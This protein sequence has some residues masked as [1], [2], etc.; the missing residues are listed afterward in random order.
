MKK[1][2]SYLLLIVS[3]CVTNSYAQKTAT[4]DDYYKGKIR[5]K[6]KE[7]FFS[8]IANSRVAVGNTSEETDVLG[9][10]SID[11]LSENN[12][13]WRI[14]RVFPYSPKHEAKHRK[15]GLHLWYELDFEGDMNPALL[16][17]QYAILNEVAIAK[18]LFKKVSLAAGA[19]PVYWSK[20]VESDSI[21]AG[22]LKVSQK[23]TA[24]TGIN[25]FS[26]ARV[27]GVQN[28]ND[29]FLNLQWHYQNDGSITG[30]KGADIDL[31]AAWSI[32][33]NDT[34]ELK[35]VVV[36]V[37]DGGIDI[38][39]EDLV[40]NLWINEAE[41]YGTE[42]VDDDG[43]GYID[44]IH[45]YNFV[46]GSSNIS[47]HA[48]GTHVAGTVGAVSNNG[49][50]VA[51]VAGGDGNGNGVKLISCQV[52]DNQVRGTGVDDF[53]NAIIY[54]A[55]NGAVISQN[56]WGYTVPGKQEEEV[57]DA[58]QYFI[59][60]AGRYEGSPMQGGILIFAAGNTGYNDEHY[61]AAYDEVV[62]VAALGP[63]DSIAT[64]STHGTW[65]DISAP[66]GDLLAFGEEGQIYSTLP[67]NNYG[68]MEGT[69][70]ATPHVSGVAALA[71]A[72]FGGENFRPEDLRSMLLG[73][74]DPLAWNE[75]GYFGVGALNARNV[76]SEDARIAPEAITDLSAAETYHDAIE[77]SWTVPVDED[78]FQPELFYLSLDREEIT[79][80]N[81]GEQ[82]YNF[83]Y[84]NNYEAGD[85]ITLT[86]NGLLKQTDYWFAIKSADR[87]GN[88]SNLSNILKV[89]TTDVPKFAESTRSI[90]LNINVED[91]P[92]QVVPVTFANDGDGVISWSAFS[93]NE[94][95]A[96]IPLED[97]SFAQQEAQQ[98]VLAAPHRYLPTEPQLMQASVSS[99][100]D[101]PNYI[102]YDNT[103]VRAGFRYYNDQGHGVTLAGSGSK[104]SGLV[105]STRFRVPR[106]ADFNWTHVR[107]V[108]YLTQKEKPVIVELKKGAENVQDAETFYVQEY[109]ADTTDIVSYHNI[110]IYRP[111][112]LEG[113]EYFF[114]VLHFPKEEAFPLLLQENNYSGD[115]T[116]YFMMSMDKGVSF[117]DAYSIYNR[118]FPYVDALSSGEDG[119]YVFINPLEGKI[120]AGESM[121]VDVTVDGTNLT[122]GY[123][124]NTIGITT[125]D[126][127]KPGISIEVKTAVT[128]QKPAVEFTEKQYKYEVYQGVE[129]DLAVSIRNTGLDTLTVTGLE[130]NG[131]TILLDSEVKI[132]AQTNGLVVFD[133]VAS[134]LGLYAGNASLLTDTENGAERFNVVITTIEQ[135]EIEA[136]LISP[137]DLMFNYD[138]TATVEL[139]VTN[140][141]SSIVSYDL[142]HYHIG[143]A[144][145]GL[146][147]EKLAYKVTS[148]DEDGGPVEGTW[149]DITEVGEF[150]GT[151]LQML[152]SQYDL[153]TAFPYYN[154]MLQTLRIAPSYGVLYVNELRGLADA[155]NAI[156][157]LTSQQIEIIEMYQYAFGDREVFTFKNTFN[158]GLRKTDGEIDFYVQV[159]FFRDGA[160]EFRYKGVDEAWAEKEHDYMI[161]IQGV[162]EDDKLLYKEEKGITPKIHDGLVIRFEPKEGS[163]VSMV[164]DASSYK[165]E[166]L[167]SE[168]KSI[169][170]TLNPSYYNLFEGAY[171]NSVILKSNSTTPELEF[172][173]DITLL[174]DSE[175]SILE[176]ENTEILFDTVRIGLSQEKYFLVRNTGRKPVVLNSL[177]FG[178]NLD[179]TS[180]VSLP[181]TINPLSHTFIPIIFEPKSN[182]ETSVAVAYNFD[183]GQTGFVDL[184]GVGESDVA[185]T[186]TGLPEHLEVNL[187]T[188][189]EK[190]FTF[191]LANAAEDTH[192]QY[193][194]ENGTHVRLASASGTL[195]ENSERFMVADYGYRWHFSDETKSTYKWKDIEGEGE[196]IEAGNY[197]QKA[198]ALP[199]A[200][201][202][203]GKMYD[204]LWV[205]DNGYVAVN[206]LEE[207]EYNTA[208]EEG[209]GM[210]GL[211]APF[212]STLKIIDDA[213]G[214]HYLA[215]ED[216]VYFQWSA[217]GEDV[218]NSPGHVVFQVEILKDGRIFFH[219]NKL[220]G[221]QGILQYGLESPDEKYDLNKLTTW[222]LRWSGLTDSTTVSIATPVMGKT[223]VG[224]T[225]DFEFKVASDR[226]FKAGTYQDT[227]RI[228]TNSIAQPMFE[229]PVTLNV[230]G[231]PVLTVTDSLVWE[232]KTVLTSGLTLEKKFT[233][234]N[235][236]T[237]NLNISKITYEGLDN[238]TLYDGEGEEV[239]LSFSGTLISPIGVEPWETTTL[240]VA[241]PVEQVGDIEGKINI[242]TNAD[243][244]ESVAVKASI[245]ESPVFDWDATN[246][247]YS[248]NATDTLEYTFQ[249]ETKGISEADLDIL[250]LP[251]VIPTVNE[252]ENQGPVYDEI[253]DLILDDVL[254]MDS[255]TWEKKEE[256]DGVFN[257]IL[258]GSR[259]Y[260]NSFIAPERGF[261]MTHVK[262]FTNINAVQE[263]VKISIYVGGGI[264]AGR[265]EGPNTTG[266][267]AYQQ[268]YIVHQEI[269]D[270][271]VTYAFKKPI[272]IPGGERFWVVIDQPATFGSNYYHGFESTLDVDVQQT[273]WM[274]NKRGE[275]NFFWMDFG[276]SEKVVWKMRPL[277][278]AGE[279]SWLTLTPSGVTLEQGAEAVTVTAK[280]LPEFAEIGFNRAKIVAQTNDVNN[281]KLD[282]D[283][284][285]TINGAPQFE[286]S[287][288]QYVDTL[289]ITETE[290]YVG[291]YYYT[292]PEGEELSISFGDNYDQL[293]ARF[294]ET[295]SHTA[296]LKI[297]TDYE[298][299]GVYDYPVQLSDASG[300]TIYDTL[301]VEV[302]D[303]NRPPY[304]KEEYRQLFLNLADSV[305]GVTLAASD[306]F[307]DPDGDFVAIGLSGYTGNMFDL[308]IG[309]SYLD[310]H[311]RMAGHGLIG[312]IAS[313][314]REDGFVSYIIDVYISEESEEDAQ[315]SA[316]SVEKEVKEQMKEFGVSTMVYPNPMKSSDFVN[317]AFKLEEQA[318]VSV[319]I[320]DM[321]G[322]IVASVSEVDFKK[323][324]YKLP[325]NMSLASE[326]MYISRLIVNG[327]VVETEKILKSL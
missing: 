54:G 94:H 3:L 314:F 58:I 218:N 161:G 174:D 236:G 19:K 59:E 14:K 69:S 38:V 170:I 285:V 55:D 83:Q 205:S 268:R 280:V 227:L 260:A 79:E 172:P 6:L 221:W 213:K 258:G 24:N 308:A 17:E 278:A 111:Q 310:I 225:T 313:D 48:H 316:Y 165:G 18:P 88:V 146:M 203:Y 286:Y 271:W 95:P 305:E 127:Y 118:I 128:G 224:Q 85:T 74:T 245:V 64:Y 261:T 106:E 292:D 202:F 321:Y 75:E 180:R 270:Q 304:L 289:R 144:M 155:R 249:V 220:E 16:A 131:E 22:K 233:V 248:I 49:I 287:P 255:V 66:G 237:S 53:A 188:G 101:V 70:M 142:S 44:D 275:D 77:L 162:D 10:S 164:A 108:M 284:E 159:A 52:F 151:Q 41:M 147:S 217:L 99:L 137:S 267:L 229:V 11:N 140:T 197:R 263:Y 114:V 43:N 214:V 78:N 216:R 173:L 299:A 246:Q 168:S 298:S 31:F 196:I 103:Q 327:K 232:D 65:V 72:Y 323:G 253:G 158:T 39:H 123:H 302:V 42:G 102:K 125:N 190:T 23:A 36:A 163:Y 184:E 26:N 90:E 96:Y 243:N 206:P 32:V 192:V 208:F 315:A 87:F 68:Y 1:V 201:P 61:P 204:T 264:P 303:K 191:S 178:D 71:V 244:D 141:S 324:T 195:G 51:G 76:L 291:N 181:L 13:I 242:L 282:I 8:N 223:E 67:D 276:V 290:E 319:E 277:T 86:I 306:L 240:S 152:E 274:A 279:G 309:G 171:K 129:T 9:I 104:N 47:P 35:D 283:F 112:Y 317:V 297:K 269:I 37:V 281:P 133:Y 115:Y 150:V 300:N 130:L 93:N 27:A 265:E 272:E 273:A 222:I 226:V 120:A 250:L 318:R 179:F 212:W 230:T 262:S 149:D 182:G 153:E 135:P 4:I 2:L 189:E 12:K 257:P 322:Q 312:L 97:W 145:N 57:Y 307:A 121:T 117:R 325:V 63:T 207:D 132:P 215:E 138:E 238:V 160:I 91:N 252:G 73:G 256:A 7:E 156:Y 301:T 167:P 187:V 81:F 136:E 56:S 183:N 209:D 311:P 110:P 266:E 175:Q 219:Y 295:G 124:L 294:E 107:A 105:F 177:D 28:T 320:Y 33:Y 62:A 241:I 211:I 157:P 194:V 326:G 113:D 259:V 231:K 100:T 293:T 89:T 80:N 200:F 134:E 199:F 29:P 34:T 15:H 109:Y 82:A 198:V 148:S 5:I 169:S 46:M 251:L 30:S 176:I 126:L 25:S 296:Q 116:D 20:D 98:D 166:L 40:D 119:A 45:G 235:Q 210:Y 92:V 139:Q 84:R 193:R 234:Y 186:L 247:S 185:Y 60:E 239:R 228:Y 50:G 154:Q 21:K 122:N 254:V 288:N 143:K